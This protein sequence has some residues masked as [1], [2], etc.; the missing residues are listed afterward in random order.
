MLRVATRAISAE[1]PLS[2]LLLSADTIAIS[3]YPSLKSVSTQ[4][5][6]LAPNNSLQKMGEYE[7]GEALIECL[8]FIP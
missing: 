3:G 1:L 4:K 7:I 2:L 8:D 5:F 6:S